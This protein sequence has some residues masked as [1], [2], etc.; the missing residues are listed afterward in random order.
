MTRAGPESVFAAA[1]PRFFSIAS[2]R[3]FLTDFALALRAS[4]AGQSRFELSDSIVFLPTRRGTRALID[5]F[6]NTSPGGRASL[7]PRIKALGDV[8]E[9]EF[10]VFEGDAADEIDLPPAISISQRRLAL[11]KLVAEKDKVFFDGQ[12]HWAGAIAAADELGKLLDSLYTEEINPREL[13]NIVPDALAAHWRHSLSFLSIVTENWPAYLAES[14][15]MDPAERRVKLI[16]RQ[17][18]RWRQAP[19]QAPVIVAG[20]TGSA[21][22]VARMMKVVANLPLGCVVLPGLDL[23]SSPRVW[24]AIDEPHPQSGLKALLSSLELPRRDIA[25]WPQADRSDSKVGDRTSLVTVA[26][27]PAGASDDWRNWAKNAA[28]EDG[29]LMNALTNVELVEAPDEDR[30]AAAIALKLRATIEHKDRTAMLVTPDRDLARRVS[31]KMRRWDI[32]I[33]DSAGVP[34]ANTPC[35]TYL[36]LTAQWLMDVSNPVNL[37]ALLDH[38]LFGGGL[39]SAQKSKSCTAFDRALRGLKPDRGTGG[40]AAKISDD[41]H[42]DGDGKAL[43]EIVTNIVNDWPGDETSFAQ[44]FDAHLAIAERL[45]A[46]AEEEGSMRLWRGEDGETG[47]SLLAQ[48]QDGLAQINHDQPQDYAEIFSRLIANAVVRRRA[49]AH[50]RLSILGPLEARLQPA[51]LVILGGLNEGIWP[52]D[53]AIDPFLSRPMRYALGLP[54][55]E[56]RI[57]LAAHDFAQL[58]AAPAVMMTRAVRSGG[59]PAKPSRWIVRLKNILSGANALSA[60]DQTRPYEKLA[61]AL[62]EPQNSVWIKAPQPK[63]PLNVRPVDFYVTQIENLMRDPYA[64]YARHVLRLRKMDRLDESFESRHMGNLFHAILYDYAAAPLP[65]ALEQRVEV[66]NT[67]LDRRGESFGLTKD[68]RAFWSRPAQEAFDWL[69]RWDRTRRET[70]SPIILEESGKWAFN[71]GKRTF[72]LAARADRIDQSPDGGAFIVDYKTGTPPSL[73]Q[74]KSINPQLPLTGLI[75]EEGGFEKLG[76]AAIDGFEYI[77][78]LRRSTSKTNDTTAEGAAARLIIDATRE[79]LFNLLAHYQEPNTAYLSQPRPQFVDDYGD[80]DH[81]ARRRERNAMGGGE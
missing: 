81:L 19:P 70:G 2:G 6:V 22:A 55:P 65:D 67:L 53:A 34:F 48:I 74:A 80:Y 3:P 50:P 57:G 18:Q 47:A 16:N 8:E 20:T 15:L 17:T 7:L 37:M 1:C 33:D 73:A 51:D 42:F 45:A 46:T 68:H 78:V 4:L 62:D 43:L 63:P 24:D 31:L 35:G 69:V 71:I 21:P 61:D 40:L 44:R 39:T 14:G 13:E 79:R 25:P 64:I 36:R 54:S 10:I 41:K 58:T 28:A 12:R 56:R 77:R 30:E 9:D 52:R 60:I 26:L 11:A 38:P 66:L 5:A 76:R 75:V 32:A 27:R 72:S 59:K 29:A 49:P 23:S